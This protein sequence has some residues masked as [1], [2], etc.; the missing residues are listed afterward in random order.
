MGIYKESMRH[1]VRIVAVILVIV[2]MASALAAQLSS[3]SSP[4][5]QS[6]GC[7]EHG[8]KSPQHRPVDYKCCV[9]GHEA[10]LLRSTVA[11]HPVQQV[12]TANPLGVPFITQIIGLTP[13]IA[14]IPLNPASR[15]VPLRV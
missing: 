11:P 10:A 8:T 4:H 1:A 5:E 9:A 6:A 3:R 2:G 7:H 14:M 12:G 13:S 15:T